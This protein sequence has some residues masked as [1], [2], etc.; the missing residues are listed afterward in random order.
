MAAPV[1]NRQRGL[2][3]LCGL[4]AANPNC[5]SPLPCPYVGHSLGGALAVLAALEL[6]KRHPA[7][8]LT[9]CTF[10]CP[11]VSALGCRGCA[12]DVAGAAQ[13]K[14]PSGWQA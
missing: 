3:Q 14:T 1:Y 8:Q 13:D 7:S 5:P 4:A 9:V 12:K 10:G 11:R 2:L 6:R